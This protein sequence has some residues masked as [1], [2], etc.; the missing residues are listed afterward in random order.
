MAKSRER[1][2]HN[3]DEGAVG[4][5]NHSFEDLQA[6][7][8]SAKGTLAELKAAQPR[9]DAAVYAQKLRIQEIAAAIAACAEAGETQ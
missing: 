3:Q 9:D 7:H 5:A 2:R 1:S 6:A 4:A 8:A